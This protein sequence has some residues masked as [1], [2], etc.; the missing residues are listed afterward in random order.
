MTARRV[1][2]GALLLTQVAACSKMRT[3]PEPVPY[4]N[5]M[6]PG[7]L[8]VTPSGGLET[9]ILAPQL[10]G[11]SIMGW[12]EVGQQTV[13]PLAEIEQVRARE[14]DLTR[15]AL[16]ATGVA[17]V[18]VALG[19][20][21]FGGYATCDSFGVQSSNCPGRPHEGPL[22]EDPQLSVTGASGIRISVP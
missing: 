4:M 6:R 8:W 9:V 13:V 21:I 2:A 10:Y 14:F 5:T 12:D 22:T 19:F 3:L 20:A 18:A 7:Q 17:G 11:D 15:T 1:I 16:L